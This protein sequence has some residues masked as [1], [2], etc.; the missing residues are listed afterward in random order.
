[1]I[2]T[3]ASSPETTGRGHRRRRNGLVF[4]P[5][6]DVA[7]TTQE[8]EQPGVAVWRWDAKQ[9]KLEQVQ[10]LISS[11]DTQIASADTTGRITTADLHISPDQRFLY[12]S[13]RD[14]QAELD[15]IIAYGIDPENGI[16]SGETLPVSISPVFAK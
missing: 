16:K 1:M 3:P 13:S 5:T 9:G 6:L 4:H 15:Q 12:I 2:R 8:R 11:D 14:K 7:Y 10:S